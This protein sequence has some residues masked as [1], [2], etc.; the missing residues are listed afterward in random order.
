MLKVSSLFQCCV[1]L[2]CSSSAIGTIK[3]ESINESSD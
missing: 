2:C 3:D 1:V